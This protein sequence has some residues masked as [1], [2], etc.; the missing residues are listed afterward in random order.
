MSDRLYRLRRYFST[1][2]LLS[3]ASVDLVLCHQIDG[4]LIYYNA[5]LI[6]PFFCKTDDDNIDSEELLALGFTLLN[7]A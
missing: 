4:L 3:N 5:F 6:P 7:Q 2:R 1:I